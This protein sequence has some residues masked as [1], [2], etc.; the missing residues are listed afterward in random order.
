M[1]LLA[2][3]IFGCFMVAG[4]KACYAQTLWEDSPYNW[5]NSEFNLKNTD[6]DWYNSPYNWNNSYA[7]TYGKNRIYDNNGN[8]IGYGPAERIDTPTNFFDN[9]GNRLGYKVK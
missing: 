9:N 7:N 1:K 8:S 3:L 4:Q 5:A 2:G 6:A